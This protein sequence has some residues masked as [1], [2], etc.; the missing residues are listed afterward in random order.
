MR[1]SFENLANPFIKEI[2]LS[3]DGLLLYGFSNPCAS[4][5]LAPTSISVVMNSKKTG[6]RLTKAT[7]YNE[8]A[9][10][11]SF[12]GTPKRS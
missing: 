10:T 4:S 5:N 9:Q 2:Y 8:L 12:Y 11:R 7:T 3:R 1:H 6:G